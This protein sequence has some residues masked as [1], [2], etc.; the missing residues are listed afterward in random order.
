MI[1]KKSRKV[2]AALLIGA[3]V[4]ASGTFA[5]FNS[6]ANMSDFMT[7]D[8]ARKLSITNGHV[9]VSGNITGS[10]TMNA[11]WSY[12]V[13]KLSNNGATEVKDASPDILSG[14]QR[15][16]TTTAGSISLANGDTLYR[17]K[18]GAAIPN[19][20]ITRTRPGDAIVLGD[21]S[22]DDTGLEILNASNLTTKIQLRF[23]RGAD[24]STTASEA[25][26]NKLNTA[27]WK[28]YFNGTAYDSL[29]DFKD[30]IETIEY[31]APAL[32]ASQPSNPEPTAE[33]TYDQYNQANGTSLDPNGFQDL[34]D[35]WAAY[36]QAVSNSKV[37][38]FSLRLELPLETGND[39]QN[40]SLGGTEGVEFDI[41]DLFEIVATQENNP[42]WSEDGTSI[43]VD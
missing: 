40:E 43:N 27:G 4:C 38:T 37:K 24:G 2:V 13:S 3:T 12:G 28:F 17:T 16:E 26:F 10:E 30:A 31:Y 25:E 33:Q 19:G 18:V 32:E 29:Q 39:Q 7:N 36:N 42:S 23:K 15:L 35:E 9:V 11:Y 1:S 41:N 20:T 34:K 5:Y 21:G 14:G 6:K 8:T 22:D